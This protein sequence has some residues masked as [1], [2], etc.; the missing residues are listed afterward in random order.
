MIHNVAGALS[1]N[2]T[3]DHEPRNIF[4][5]DK[6]SQAVTTFLGTKG[7]AERNS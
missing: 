4:I 1:C 3:H 2:E 7:P 6:Y 5:V